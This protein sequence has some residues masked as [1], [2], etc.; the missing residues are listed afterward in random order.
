MLRRNFSHDNDGDGWWFDTD[1]INVRVVH[2]RFVR[3]SRSG[4]FY[5]VSYDAVIRDNVFR[6]NGRDPAWMGSGLRV[7]SSQDVEVSGNRFVNNRFSTLSVDSGGRGSG[8]YGVHQTVGLFVHDNVFYVDG[9]VGSPYGSDDIVS[10]AANNRFEAN[11][12]VVSDSSRA[13]WMWGPG[14]R[15]GWATWRSF[16]FDLRGSLSEGAA[17]TRARH[18]RSSH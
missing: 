16:G 1:N 18:P 5:E 3:N 4:F 12:Y 14:K 13:W 8:A 7:A 2:N 11:D 10:T 6:A 9:Y 15:I 17:A